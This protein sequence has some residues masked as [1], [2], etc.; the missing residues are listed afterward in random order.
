MYIGSASSSW[1]MHV[2]QSVWIFKRWTSGI[3]APRFLCV[4]SIIAEP[5]YLY[6]LYILCVE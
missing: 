5:D 6:C 4:C 2:R 1:K 3:V